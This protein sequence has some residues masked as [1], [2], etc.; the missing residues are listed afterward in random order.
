VKPDDKPYWG[1]K[2]TTTPWPDLSQPTQ[3]PLELG[4]VYLLRSGPHYKIGKTKDF[5]SRLGQIKLQLPFDV[6]VVHK[7]ET[8]DPTGIESYWHRRFMS[9]RDNG[10]WF[11]LS[12]EDVAAFTS[13]TKM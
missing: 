6:E 11:S 13:R 3:K 12:V 7:I 5:D 1:M 9:K 2:V 10:E 8:D 4:I